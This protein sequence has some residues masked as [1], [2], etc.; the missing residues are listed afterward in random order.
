VMK[1][2][3][4]LLQMLLRQQT[5]NRQKMQGKCKHDVSCLQSLV[6]RTKGSMWVKVQIPEK[7]SNNMHW[8]HPKK[9]LLM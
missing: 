8:N 2:L 6:K 3:F 1:K 7:G 5:P 4:N 9:C